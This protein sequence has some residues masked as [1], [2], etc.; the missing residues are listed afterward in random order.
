M[1][2]FLFIIC[3]LVMKLNPKAVQPSRRN[4][5]VYTIINTKVLNPTFLATINT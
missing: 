3:T 5:N 1:L 2:F 4:Y